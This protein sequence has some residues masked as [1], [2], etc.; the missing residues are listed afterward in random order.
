MKKRYLIYPAMAL[1]LAGCAK[2]LTPEP[3]A[4]DPDLIPLNIDGSIDQV[5]T[6]VNAAR[7]LIPETRLTM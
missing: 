3:V 1:L 6:K 2:E 4:E 5:Q 7:S